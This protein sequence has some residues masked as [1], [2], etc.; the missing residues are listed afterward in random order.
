MRP[1]PLI[2]ILFHS[3]AWTADVRPLLPGCIQKERYAMIHE[4]IELGFQRPPHCPSANRRRRRL[5]RARWWFQRMRRVVDRALD[6]QQSPPPRPEQ[7]WF[8]E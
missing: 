8:P 6:W 4:Q 2:K 7:I 3:E 1:A 5:S